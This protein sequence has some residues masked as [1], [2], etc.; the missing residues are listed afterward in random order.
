MNKADSNNNDAKV[1]SKVDP[2]FDSKIDPKFQSNVD[3]NFQTKFDPKIEAKNGPKSYPSL[4]SIIFGNFDSKVG[5]TNFD[6]ATNG[7]PKPQHELTANLKSQQPN[8]IAHQQSTVNKP[9]NVPSNGTSM[10][11]TGN[12]EKK[13]QKQIP[14]VFDDD[15]FDFIDNKNAMSPVAP[16]TVS[17]EIVQPIKVGQQMNAYR[18]GAAV[19][20]QNATLSW[21]E[22]PNDVPQTDPIQQWRQ[23]SD[24]PTVAPSI[25][26]IASSTP[27]AT[28]SR[29]TD[30]EIRSSRNMLEDKPKVTP[31]TESI[32]QNG[33]IL[34]GIGMKLSKFLG[35]FFTFFSTFENFL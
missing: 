15:L 23:K 30:E 6:R 28:E 5:S 27:I 22:R 12:N 16:K 29:K 21:R 14:N 4:E 10:P 11:K 7:F 3:P 19:T 31:N 13:P 20:R 8:K 17:P 18:D 2:A 35:F 32:I 26:T 33:A 34:T 25:P 1:Y 9:V 24:A